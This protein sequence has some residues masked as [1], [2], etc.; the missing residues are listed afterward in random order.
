[1]EHKYNP[2]TPELVEE[3]KKVVGDRYVKTDEEYLEQYQTDEEGNPHFFKKP[4]VVVFPG[5]T[6]EVAEVVKLANKFLVPITPRSAG[7]GVACGAIPIYHGMVVEL[8][9]MNKILKLDADNFYAVCQ[10][11]VFTGQLQA[12]ARKAG[13]MYAGDPSSAE[14]C[15]IGGNVAYNAGGNRAVRYGTTRDQIYALKVVTPTGDIV[16]VGARLKKC[17]T[18]LCLEQLFA[19]SEGTLVIITVF[20]V[21]LRSLPLNS[22]YM[23]CVF[24]TDKEAFALPNKILKAG[25]DPTSIEYMGNSAIDMTCKYL[26][27]M[28]MPH[29]KEGCCYVIVTVERFDQDESDRKMV[30]LCDL[31]EAN[32]S[33]DEN[34]T[35]QRIWTLRKQF[36]E[37]ARDIDRMFQ[38][39]DFVVPL[40]KIAEMTAQIPELEKKYNLYTVTVAHIGDGNIHVLP[41]NKYGLSPEE[42]FKTIKAFHADL[43]PRVYA[44]GGKMSGEHGIGYKKLEE[45]AR[46]TPEGEVKLIK[47]IKQALDPNNIMNPGKLVD[48]NGDFVA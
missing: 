22:F 11:G 43:I 41:L 19:G 42:W 36:A 21:Y 45:F 37:A 35:D 28:D 13:V 34:K 12:E 33:I 20:S 39:E 31:A 32:G 29:V 26:D 7:T 38:T 17:S 47:A 2:V 23:V 9:R 27:N 48:V 4:E 18:G 15:Q 6:E 1:M 16:D 10:T 30:N 8:Q 40:D 24:N 44:L 3:L 46:C 14:S 5:T 25:I